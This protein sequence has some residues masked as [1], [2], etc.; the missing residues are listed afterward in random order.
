MEYDLAGVRRAAAP[1][2]PVCAKAHALRE[3]GHDGVCLIRNCR[4]VTDRLNV[5][6]R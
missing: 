1:D 6:N 5:S 3:L 2:E 4:P